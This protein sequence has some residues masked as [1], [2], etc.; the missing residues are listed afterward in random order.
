[1]TNQKLGFRIW[2]YFFLMTNI[3]QND[4]TYLSSQISNLNCKWTLLHTGCYVLFSSVR[5]KSIL[6]SQS[7][8]SVLPSVKSWGLKATPLVTKFCHRK[9]EACPYTQREAGPQITERCQVG[10]VSHG[11]YNNIYFIKWKEIN[12]TADNTWKQP[13]GFW[14]V[15]HSPCQ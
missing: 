7:A 8:F 2:N 13:Q 1:M 5:V 12:S 6:H 11:V 15:V 10:Q 3:K 14:F 9:F 4:T